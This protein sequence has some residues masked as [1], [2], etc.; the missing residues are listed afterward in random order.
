MLYKG[1]ALIISLVSL[2]SVK[3]EEH[4]QQAHY[5]VIKGSKV[6]GHMWCSKLEK[7]GVVEY[8]TES[9]VNISL[10]V[11]ISIYNKIQSSFI[12]GVLQDGSMQRKVNGKQKSN[13]H[14]AWNKDKYLITT[15]EDSDELK[16]KIYFTTGCL[17]YVEPENLKEI[18]SEN[19]RQFISVKQ[20]A[21]HKYAIQLPDGKENYYTYKNGICVEV[22]V[23]TPLATVYIRPANT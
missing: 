14:I 1:I 18:Y 5:H 10:L 9:N 13:T 2:L 12:N 3:N 6:V 19:F 11:D 17:M 23:P 21:P 16:L 20:V 8:T 22:E 4:F 7:N 15:T